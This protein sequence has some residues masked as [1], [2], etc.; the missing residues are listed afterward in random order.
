MQEIHTKEKW[1]CI[2]SESTRAYSHTS[3]WTPNIICSKYTHYLRGWLHDKKQSMSYAVLMIW[4][5]QEN[6]D[7]D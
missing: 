7:K 6:H 4:S 1:E 5:Q 3:Q 2:T